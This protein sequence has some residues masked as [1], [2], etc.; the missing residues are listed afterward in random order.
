[1]LEF[2]DFR[3]KLTIILPE[4]TQKKDFMK[5]ASAAS[6]F[7]WNLKEFRD[8]II[9]TKPKNEHPLY[10]DLIKKSLNFKFENAIDSVAK[11]MNHYQE[12]YIKECDC[13]GD[14]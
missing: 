11:F 9:H 8:D 3:T 13:E 1:M 7:I 10:D 14:F 12:D 2:I 6:S 4:V 5:L